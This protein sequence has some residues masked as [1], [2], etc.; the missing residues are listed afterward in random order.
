MNL[1]TLDDT[2][3]LAER[4][5][6]II[7]NADL[8]AL[9]YLEPT[10]DKIW[11][12]LFTVRDFVIEKKRKVYG[13]FAL[14]KL[15]EIVEPKDKFY[16]DDNIK[17]WDI[18]FYSPDPKNDAKEIANR[19][20]KKGFHHIMA[21]DAQHDETYK[22]FAETLDCADISYVPK[23]IYNRMPFIE[24]KGMYITGPHFMMI[25][26]FR[27][28]SDPMRSYFRL[29]KT[30]DRLYLMMKHYPLPKNTSSI[31]IEPPN[32]DLDI[33]LRTIHESIIGRD[34]II[35]I[36][37]Y[38]YNHFIRES[39]I[40]EKKQQRAKTKKNN[41]NET[42]INYIDINYYELVST[43]YKK[44]AKEIIL[45]LMNK[46][47]SSKSKIRYQEN[48]PFFTYLGYNVT[49]YYDEEI[50]CKI[51]HYG[52]ICIPYHDVPALYFK[53]GSYEKSD[54]KKK[55]KIG[56]FALVMM[57]NLISI[58]KA[59]VDNDANT[60]NLYYTMISHIS[61]M[62]NYYFENNKKTIFD[63]SL[64]QEFILRC[65]GK[66]ASAQMEKQER[67]ERLKKAGKRYTWS[68]NP[69][70]EKDR[71]NE[72]V[73]YFKNSSGNKI[74]NPRN[75]KIS[76]SGNDDNEE[77]NDDETVGDEEDK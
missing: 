26:Y 1:Y 71:D 23:N 25:D 5:D 6:E 20:H 77:I 4:E 63:E 50:I 53:K 65:T 69:D 49:I 27:V 10:K 43:D 15:I 38:A 24:V 74:N 55:I 2:I 44:D 9:Q 12:I 45:N 57:Y 41:N 33:A 22:V 39:K 46:F 68:Y 73:Y 37:M 30:F 61:L 56:S 54:D 28:L 52:S 7:K 66:T 75:Y 34:S 48:Y 72:Y 47:P 29:K 21:R 14:N 60:K 19:L 42:Y 70:N 62:K 64:F 36:G 31:E 76:L 51:Y 32:R 8:L 58:M 40:S 3:A 11:D 67:M 18:D 16:D 17:A 13:G 59:R 35:A